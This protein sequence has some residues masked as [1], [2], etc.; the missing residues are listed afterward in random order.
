MQKGQWSV[1]DDLQIIIFKP[2]HN[3][4]WLALSRSGRRHDVL[5]AVK[6]F[7]VIVD[8]EERYCGQVSAKAGMPVARL[9]DLIQRVAQ[10]RWTI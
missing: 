10:E 7:A 1:R 6:V 9:A 8:R 3:S 4:A 5:S 2:F